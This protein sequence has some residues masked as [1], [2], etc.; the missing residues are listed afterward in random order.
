MQQRQTNRSNRSLNVTLPAPTGGLNVRDSMDLMSANDAIVMD[1]YIPSDTKVMLRR[2]YAVYADLGAKIETLAPYKK[3]DQERFIAVAGGKAY[4]ITTAKEVKAYEDVSFGRSNC[5]ICQYRDRLYFVNGTDTPKAFYVDEGG[6]DV[7]GDW[8]FTSEEESFSPQKIINATVSKERLWFVEKG[9]L[10]VWY[11]ENTGEV[12]GKLK[13]FD[14]QY[15]AKHGGEL[16]AVANWTQDGG[17]GI[18]DLTVFITSEGE[19]LVYS[20]TDPGNA[21]LWA[22]KGSYIMS[23][24]IGYKCVMQYQGDI[25]MISED[26][27]VPLSKALPIDKANASQIAFSDKIRGLVLDRTKNN[28][29]RE[30]WQGII[31]GRG[32]YALFN[33]PV[34]NQFE[35]HVINLNTGA[36]CRFTN[37]RSF[38]WAIFLDRAYFGSDKGVYLFDEGYSDNGLHIFG[39]VKQA[40]SDLGNPNLKKIQMLNPRTKSS[41]K[42]ALVIYTDMD[43]ES[44]EVAYRENIGSSGGSKWDVSPWSSLANPIGTK[45]STLQGKIRSQWIANAATGFKASVVFK[46]KTRGNLIE[47]FDTGVRYEAGSGIV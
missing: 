41:T 43:F 40:F 26:G 47:W 22:L 5:Q 11:A 19:C 35:Q 18:D 37:I 7:F 12:Q 1:N 3:P 28:R 46:T 38:C 31:Y 32:G 29:S 21:G 15:V 44:R 9:S 2:G 13:Q 17:Q 39:V 4:N 33:V 24:P 30:G 14:L 27:Y 10:K 16:V 25:V 23:K 20:G 8:G 42:Y 36:W 34:Y 6:S 45:W